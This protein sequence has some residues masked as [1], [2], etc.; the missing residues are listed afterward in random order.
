MVSERTVKE[1][2]LCEVHE[3]AARTRL[4]ELFHNPGFVRLWLSGILCGALRWL[5]LL[6]IGL[7]VLERTGSPLL[8]AVLTLVRMAPMLLFGIPAGA[9]AD[10]YDRRHLLIA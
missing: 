10:R 8:V 2:L 1:Q 9:L 3:P 6:A 5:E 7:F 4:G